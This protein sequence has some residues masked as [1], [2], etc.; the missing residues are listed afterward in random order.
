M[1]Y[2]HAVYYSHSF[3]GMNDSISSVG[4]DSVGSGHQP[5]GPGP[6]SQQ[7]NRLPELF[8]GLT[9][10]PTSTTRTTAVPLE[11][12]LIQQYSGEYASPSRDI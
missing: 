11:D 1:I 3:A 2:R 10:N 8:D 12:S 7:A 4:Q 9:A 5:I 6:A